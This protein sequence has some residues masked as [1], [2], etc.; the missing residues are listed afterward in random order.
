MELYNDTTT[1]HLLIREQQTDSSSL[2]TNFDVEINALKKTVEAQGTEISRLRELNEKIVERCENQK[3]ILRILTAR[4]VNIEESIKENPEVI[5]DL[6]NT[7]DYDNSDENMRL[8]MQYFKTRKAVTVAGL[9][10]IGVRFEHNMQYIRFLQKIEK[11][12]GFYT[13]KTKEGKWVARKK[14]T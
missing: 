8:V 6:T 12:P 2:G 7:F 11:F 13:T 3:D 1:P 9:K 14:I 5:H 4:I 10:Q